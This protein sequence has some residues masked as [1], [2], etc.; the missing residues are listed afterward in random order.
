MGVD[1]VTVIEMGLELIVLGNA[2]QLLDGSLSWGNSV[3]VL[4]VGADT[5]DMEGAPNEDLVHTAGDIGPFGEH[6][7]GGFVGL[8]RLLDSL[9]AL[10]EQD[11]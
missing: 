6:V 1:L 5:L 8:T 4:E 10:P 11:L 7:G 9:A 3:H 2:E